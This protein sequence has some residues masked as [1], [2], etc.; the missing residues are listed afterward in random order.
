MRGREKERG[1]GGGRGEKEN[2]LGREGEREM[3]GR[4]KE[5]G[6]GGRRKRPERK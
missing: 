2:I 4:E 3:R 5:R 6:E 1:E